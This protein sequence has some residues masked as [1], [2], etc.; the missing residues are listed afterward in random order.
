LLLGIL[1]LQMDFVSRDQL[2]AAMNAWVLE[3]GTPLGDILLAQQA[4]GRDEYEL[5]NA[6][7]AKHLARHDGDAARSLAAVSSIE[8][9][10]A[11]LTRLADP[12]IQAS[13]I[14]VASVRR[15]HDPHATQSAGAPTSAAL[16]F[17]VLRPHARGGLGEVFVAEDEEL[18]R[19]VALKQI[20]PNR[21]DHP[22]SRARFVLEAEITGGLEHPGIVPVYGLGSYADG[23]PFY[24]MRFI[25]GDS[26]ADAIGQFHS[27][28]AAK[29]DRGERTLRL[30]LLLGRFIDVCN[31]MEYAHSRGIL[32]RDLK[33]GNIMLGKYGETLVVDWGLAKPIGRSEAAKTDGGER[34][35]QPSSAS[36]SSPTQMGVA[37]GTPQYMSPEQA[38]GQLDRLGPTSDV[39]SL[40]ATLYC[41]LTG[42]A[43]LS[44]Q[45]KS[46]AGDV[47]RLVERGEIPW[48][49]AIKPEI[50]K[51]LEAICRKAMALKPSDRYSSPRALADDIE[52]WLADEPIVA[53]CDTCSERIAR[54]GR[55]HRGFAR[56]AAAGLALVA[57]VAILAA[58]LVNQQRRIA[59]E[60][61]QRANEQSR[62]ALETLKS[63]V[64]DIQDELSTVPGAQE[65]RQH[66]LNTA[67][68]RLQ[69]VTRTLDTAVETDRTAM[70]SHLALG[71]TLLTLGASKNHAR[72]TDEARRQYQLACDIGR[73]LADA[74]PDD[75]DAQRD[76]S[77]AY[78]RLG[79]VNMQSGHV[80]AARDV[81]LKGLEISRKLNQAEP[82]S[83]A[84]QRD[85]SADHSRLGEV[86]LRLGEVGLARDAFQASFAINFKL[87]EADPKN[88]SA[89]RDLAVIY[90]RL[91][92]VNLQLG[93]MPAAREA[94]ERGLAI[95]RRLAAADD[96]N[97]Q[98]QRDL[99]AM[100]SRLGDVHVRSNNPPAARDAYQKSLEVSRKQA[101]ADPANPQA[102][103]NLSIC[104]GRLCDL[105]RQAG[106]AP[107]ALGACRKGLEI[108]L[109]LAT[110]DP[111]NTLLQRDLSLSYEKLGDVNLL[112][113]DAKEAR[114]AYQKRLEISEKLVAVDPSDIEL[115][116]DLASSYWRLGT[117]ANLDEKYAR[118]VRWLE[119]GVRVLEELDHAGKIAQPLYQSWLT[120][121]RA[122]LQTTKVLASGLED[123]DALLR[124][125][126]SDIPSLLAIRGRAMAKEGKHA[127]AAE[128]ADK[129]AALEPQ[130]GENHFH[131]AEAYALCLTTPE[132]E[133]RQRLVAGPAMR[134]H[135]AAR[136]IEHLK[137]AQ[138]AGY[139]KGPAQADLS[140]NHNFDPLRSREDFQKLFGPI[141]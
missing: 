31:A 5:L 50:A 80:P 127:A 56:A 102:L 119:R 138:A 29:L 67:V 136:A 108:S 24:A 105:D 19:E 25:R 13:L 23:R 121:Q 48:P 85:L 141:R 104:Y 78:E 135:Y 12:D 33:P 133:P 100:Y 49:R 64:F 139:L 39:Y 8:T 46:Y 6:L 15:S 84:V 101:Q 140:R 45:S 34:T 4:L 62:L 26:L 129:L 7:V 99:A 98:A 109:N 16:R 95:S 118:G 14:H 81:Y 130:S 51:P 35:L 44:G 58:I 124:E 115:Q 17:R 107:A 69:Q 21:A 9:F 106:D 3:K 137:E 71:D 20:Q 37:I 1:A 18:R 22:E 116:T 73:A 113:G 120:Q 94:I 91:G 47:L 132:D 41:L 93:E 60:Q 103:R 117:A 32:H 28:K 89:Q 30:R 134:E 83:L 61:R 96:A 92:D 128:T 77:V 53:R 57:L 40:G 70:A 88:A 122:I 68:E 131:A 74:N 125:P 90:G 112:L 110:A 38:A 66:L 11:E 97:V 126:A 54:F 87:S 2:I 63:V 86:H 65:V 27:A 111:Q 123:L 75:F 72:A 52:H 10:R 82:T 114:D 79:D 43:P 42:E 55:R 59:D 76:L 36:N